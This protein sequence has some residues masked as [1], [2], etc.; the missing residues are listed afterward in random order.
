M[1]LELPDRRVRILDNGIIVEFELGEGGAQIAL[2]AGL[3]FV[4]LLELGEAVCVVGA[5]RAGWGWFGGLGVFGR[6]F[7]FI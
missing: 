6:F 5:G 2:F 3:G 4:F 1:P 7:T